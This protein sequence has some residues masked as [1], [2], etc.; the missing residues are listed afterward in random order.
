MAKRSRAFAGLFVVLALLSL[1]GC[2]RVSPGRVNFD[3]LDYGQVIAESWKRQTLLN[4]VRLRYAD[5]PVFL[6]IASVINSYSISGSVSAGGQVGK[7]TTLDASQAGAQLGAAGVWSNTPTVTYQPLLGDR[8]TKSM[9][10]PIP[11]SAVLQLMQGGWPVDLVMAT[12]V[13]S[14]NGVRNNSFG[15]GGDPGF[16]DL[17]QTLD[18]LQRGGGLGNRIEVRKDGSAVILVLQRESAASGPDDDV[19]RIRGLLGLEKDLNDIEVVYGLAPR[20]GREVSMIT[21]SMME[22]MLEMGMGLD[23]PASDAAMGR[24]LPG[25]A[26]SGE[27]EAKP[28]V[29]IRSGTER[30]ED[31]YVAVPYKD[32]WFWIADNDIASKRTFVFLLILFSLAETGQGVAAPVVTVPSR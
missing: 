16:Q 4:V 15:V 32:H 30:P 18:R 10:Q 13:R 27:A 5:A 7:T 14:I 11:P 25:R 20:S 9:L 19:L 21:R 1:A 2:S 17:V 6:D 23:V 29:K 22:I 26:Q 12:V 28:L 31:V 24:V 8:F 3:R